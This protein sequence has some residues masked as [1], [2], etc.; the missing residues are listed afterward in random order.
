M[1]QPKHAM[2]TATVDLAKQLRTRIQ[3]AAVVDAHGEEHEA[4]SLIKSLHQ[5]GGQPLHKAINAPAAPSAGAALT[6]SKELTG[7]LRKAQP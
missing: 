5:S 1:N 6:L 7:T 3:P 4:A 2:R